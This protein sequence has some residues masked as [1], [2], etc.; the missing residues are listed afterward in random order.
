M[1]QTNQVVHKSTGNKP[2]YKQL[3]ATAAWKIA[4]ATGGVALLQVLHCSTA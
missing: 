3:A 2:P 4:S 1:N